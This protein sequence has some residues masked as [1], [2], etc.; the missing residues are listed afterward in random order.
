MRRNLFDNPF[1]I[2]FLFIVISAVN[3]LFSVHFITIT[4][5]GVA[6][7]MFL[8]CIE[9]DYYYSLFIVILLFLVI[10][11]AQGL[12]PFSLV[13]L[14]FLLYIFILPK[15]KQLFSFSGSSYFVY[16]G[17]FYISA[18]MLWSF[19][20]GFGLGLLSTVVINLIIDFVIVGIFI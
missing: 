7:L 19:V 14:S 12:K 16:I 18:Y 9:N 20:D 17:I 8:K 13:V 6:F 15:V 3:I 1:I 5:G 2:F 10:E 11:T 4:L